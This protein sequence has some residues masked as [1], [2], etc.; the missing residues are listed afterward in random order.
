MEQIIDRYINN[1]EDLPMGK[2]SYNCEFG[3]L[4]FIKDF[5]NRIILFEIYIN[6]Q[7]RRCGICRNLIL[8][9][10]TICQKNKKIFLIISV[11]SRILYDFLISFK[12]DCG[13]FILTK[14]G[15]LFNKNKLKI[16]RKI[17]K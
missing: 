12:C 4:T 3:T 10:I 5:S 15:F 2:N 8:Y 1:Y 16:S 7:Y 11:L 17:N 9:C 6:E 13:R 14:E